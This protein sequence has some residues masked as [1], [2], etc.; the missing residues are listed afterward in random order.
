MFLLRIMCKKKENI[1]AVGNML[2]VPQ[3]FFL[4]RKTSSQHQADKEQFLCTCALQQHTEC[5]QKR[6]HFGC[7]PL[8][9][10]IVNYAL[11][12]HY[13][14]L[15]SSPIDRKKATQMNLVQWQWGSVVSLPSRNALWRSCPWSTKLC[16]KETSF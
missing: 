8:D 3:P 6:V 16:Q 7:I 11:W 10:P 12:L 5:H 14:A 1:C 4:W 2:N 9:C 13:L 15:V